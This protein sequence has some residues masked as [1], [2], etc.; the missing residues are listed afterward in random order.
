ML[1]AAPLS[2][3]LTSCGND[4]P[5]PP[6][7]I[8]DPEPEPEP[9]GRHRTILVYAVASNNLVE[10]FNS[11][12]AEMLD[13]MSGLDN[14]D[15]SL[16]VYRV[17]RNGKVDLLEA[18]DGVDGKKE[19]VSIKSYA[20]D[21]LS[22]DPKR[23]QEVIADV[24]EL[25][26]AQAYCLV[27]WAHGSSWEPGNNEHVA[28]VPTLYAYGGD[29]STGV[30]DWMNIDEMASAI[31]D[32]RFD[33]IWFDN[34][35][36]SSIEVMYQL[37]DKADYIVAY[38]TEIYSPGM[39]YHATLPFLMQPEPDLVNAAKETF[40]S[41]DLFS[42]AC[43]VAVVDM[44]KIEAV[45]DATAK[46]YDNFSLI[47]TKGLQTYSRLSY[48]PY[49][50]FGQLTKRL[51]ENS[52]TFSATE[53]DAAMADFVI[54]KACSAKNFSGNKIDKDNYSGISAHAYKVYPKN[55]DY[56]RTLDWYAR[57]CPGL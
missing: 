6:D 56:F 14:D 16:V 57:V 3:S 28:D 24:T 15:Y 37:R 46:A 55:D 30:T 18:Q 2:M 45:A 50:D 12:S 8:V 32:G 33:F 38:P 7:P 51:G 48:G 41:Y 20:N 11:D 49:F 44:S 5:L 1:L 36:M 39:P 42:Y 34:C 43:T 35:F 21:V 10:D 25:R 9:E 29:Q 27:F 54:Y 40:D 13:G 26:P 23:L 4:E 52:A 47:D 17:L 19:F 22:T 31:P 53:F